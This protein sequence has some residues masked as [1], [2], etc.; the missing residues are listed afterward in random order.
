[1]LIKGVSAMSAEKT[2]ATLALGDVANAS[3]EKLLFGILFTVAVGVLLSVF[4]MLTLPKS[5][6]A[7]LDIL[8]KSV[9]EMSKGNLDAKI[10]ASDIKEFAGLSKAL[11]RMRLGQQAM[12]T[13]IRR[14][15][16]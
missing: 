5:V 12:L 9:D 16:L 3:F 2:K 14:S 7:P 10:D 6:T 11:E 1:V 8:T 15:V 13:R 4:L